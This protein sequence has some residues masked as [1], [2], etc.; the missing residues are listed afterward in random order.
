MS[1]GS[2]ATHPERSP[3]MKTWIRRSPIAA[4]TAALLLGGLAACGAH[5][6]RSGH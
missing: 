3:A 6:Q 1:M 4:T 5:S 2:F